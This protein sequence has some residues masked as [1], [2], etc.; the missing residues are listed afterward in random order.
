[1]E[2]L[3]HDY[4]VDVVISGHNHNY[5]RTYPVFKKNPTSTEYNNPAA[6]VYIVAGTGGVCI[7]EVILK[8]RYINIIKLEIIV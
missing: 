8:K 6:P 4:A 7:N 2:E 3:F 1:M 5:E